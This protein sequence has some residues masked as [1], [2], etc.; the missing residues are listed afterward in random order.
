M[1]DDKKPPN[2]QGRQRTMPWM[3]EFADAVLGGRE[4]A[5]GVEPSGMDP[6]DLIP[7]GKAAKLAGK[8][9]KRAKGFKLPSKFSVF[10]ADNPAAKMLSAEENL[11]RKAQ[12][13]KEL[14]ERGIPYRE[15]KGQYSES[16][17]SP[18]NSI[19]IPHGEGV[20]EQVVNELGKKYGQESV[21]HHAEGKN[22]LQY[23]TGEKAGQHHAGE[24]VTI[25][26][27]LEN[28]YTE[29]DGTR[30]NLGLDFDKVHGA[31]PKK[32]LMHYSQHP[33]PLK[34]LDPAF[35]GT[36]K[37]GRETRRGNIVPRTY[38]YE[39]GTKP[40]SIVAD[41]A[42][43]VHYVEA[44]E[45]I[46][47]F[48][49][50]EAAKLHVE[51]AWNDAS[52]LEKRAKELGYAG[53]KNTHPSNPVPN[54]VAL[55]D[56]QPVV[57]STPV[58]KAHG[59]AI[60]MAG[61]G[62]A[63]P[64]F[65]APPQPTDAVDAFLANPTPVQAQAS[66]PPPGLDAFI[67]PEMQAAK[68]GSLGQQAITGVEGLAQ[69]VAGPLAT[70]FETKVLGV[71]PEDIR[72]R[73]EQNPA[74]H[75]A[76]EMAGFIGPALISGGATGGIRGA[77]GAGSQVGLL[78]R[79]GEAAATQV[80]NKI[81][82]DVV[83]E[84]FVGALY[85]GGEEISKQFKEDP[86]A[87]AGSAAINI[88]L[89][90][91]A[92]GV[93][94]G[95]AGAALRAAKG[96]LPAHTPGPLVSQVD[97]PK[98]EV[99]DFQTLV[100]HDPGITKVERERILSDP[101]KW[102]KEEKK[103]AKDI[104]NVGSKYNLPVMEGMVSG[105]TFVQR[106]EDALLTGG[107]TYTS[108]KRQMV[109]DQGYKAAEQTLDRAIGTG[110]NLS[111]AQVG[112]MLGDS[113]KAQ[114]KTE[115]EPISAMY[116]AL[117][118]RAEIIPIEEAAA[119]SIAADLQKIPE[120]RVTPNSPQGQLGRRILK[121]LE[122]VQTIDDLKVL[123]SSIHDSLPITASPGERRMAAILADKLRQVEEDSIERYALKA[124]I[125]PEEQA[126]A[127][128]LPAARK[129]ANAAYK[130]F[131]EKVQTLA[132]QLGKSRVHGAQDAINF[133]D[134]LDY[135]Q[136]ASR[137]FNKNKSQ[138]IG[139][140]AK[141]FPEQMQ[142]LRGY[143]KGVM[144]D[145]A[146]RNGEFSPKAFFTAYNKL[147]PEI[148]NSL[149]TK[150]EQSVIRDM[151]TYINSFPKRYNPSGTAAQVN[152]RNTFNP[153]KAPLNNAIDMGMEQFIKRMGASPQAYDAAQLGKATVDGEKL[154]SKALKSLLDSGKTT[155]PAA[156]IPLAAHRDKLAR[157]V[158]EYKK[159]PE[160]MLE[161]GDNN[162]VPEYQEAFAATTARAVAYLNS[163]RPSDEP[164]QILD[165]KLPPS[166][167]RKAEYERALTIAQQ[168]LAILQYMAE[169]RMTPKDVQVLRV[170]YP[171][172]YKAL[173]QKMVAGIMQKKE[174]GQIIPYTLRIQMAMFLATPLDSTMTPQSIMN[175]QLQPPGGQAPTPTM[176]K[177]GAKHSM[178]GLNKLAKSYQ[179]QM[180]ARQSAQQK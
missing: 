128:M 19:L 54:A 115:N 12:L 47:D 175:S 86:E 97:A 25:D 171:S 24:G 75:V 76:S 53:F 52:D 9:L 168:P 90:G 138:F 7:V 14:E 49:S 101:R 107:D 43:N 10:T 60:A 140:F 159:S 31:P 82:K 17:D 94:G 117:K 109:Y 106:A 135:E 99:G 113:L 121:D 45:N 64:S 112:E 32:Q 120:F 74:T 84:A 38:Y 15:A 33:E 18:E 93:F 118:Q 69:G 6:L 88:G 89:A 111:K 122:N 154:A 165:A 136:L 103:N 123:K 62:M 67:A 98:M 16:F 20:D 95:A 3:V 44:P 30:F 4:Q 114:I 22:K 132:K 160:R 92:G 167:T 55:F 174:K 129:E 108:I 156:V 63:L 41:S 141:E 11:A 39:A 143:Q 177:S 51:G 172:V 161:I 173:G 71:K 70:G 68:Y 142:M 127:R 148:Q 85:Q 176:P 48:N 180:Q 42:K 162:P 91:V 139:F 133:I 1:A 83:R 87:S 81:A 150:A 8:A 169:G 36:G 170:I 27:N 137:L 29:I 166:Q 35:M 105:N 77:I 23:V 151:D 155:M 149:F 164:Q 163:I 13:V 152:L 21:V 65:P 96:A 79:A 144:R 37:A 125:T 178:S 116:N 104:R 5:E 73:E 131:I 50:P 61:G 26:P 126:A 110:E 28:Y 119:K 58:K 179:T 130:P 56:K 34:E 153:L 147:E 2:M 134:N 157:L 124:A 40:E 102:L 66:P 100:K 146:I 57:S 80:S 59:G 46:I 145:A 158:L 78:T 72:G